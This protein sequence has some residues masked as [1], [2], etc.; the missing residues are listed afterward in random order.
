MTIME[1]LI[2]VYRQIMRLKTLR[3]GIFCC[4]AIVA[5]WAGELDQFHGSGLLSVS[6]Q[7]ENT[8]LAVAVIENRFI[9]HG[10]IADIKRASK[11]IQKFTLQII[12]ILPFKDYP[13]F[14]G[15]YLNKTV[16][17]YSEIGIPSSFQTGIEVSVLLRV[18]GDERG[19]S[20]FLVEVLKN[21]SKKD[22]EHNISL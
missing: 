14:G 3:F 10:T 21:D 16:E 22:A 19:T 5:G 17:I 1:F 2:I 13:S 9:A 7:G 15:K 4:I 12:K 18:A 8:Q 11:G 20:L 6:V